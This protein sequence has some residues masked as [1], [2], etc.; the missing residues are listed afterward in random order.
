M[1][2]H[3]YIILADEP[4]RDPDAVRI[5][6]YWSDALAALADAVRTDGAMLAELR[7]FPSGAILGRHDGTGYDFT[8][9]ERTGPCHAAYR[10]VMDDAVMTC[11]R[12]AGHP[13]FCRADGTTSDAG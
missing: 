2:A 11:R 3:T 7:A 9:T 4:T 1:T 6:G 10:R 13:G 8:P 12:A 5:V